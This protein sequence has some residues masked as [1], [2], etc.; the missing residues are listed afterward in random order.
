MLS[1][2]F[3]AVAEAWSKQDTEPGNRTMYQCA[4]CTGFTITFHSGS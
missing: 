3:F 2:Q 1:R 4:S